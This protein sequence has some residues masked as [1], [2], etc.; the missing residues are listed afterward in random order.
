M[1]NEKAAA[2][3]KEISQRVTTANRV[4]LGL[5]T[6]IVDQAISPM[7]AALEFAI[8]NGHKWTLEDWAN[9]INNHAR[10][11]LSVRGEK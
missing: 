5:M 8:A 10:A 1:S 4:G 3:A 11:A 6:E 2:I 9:W 7:Q